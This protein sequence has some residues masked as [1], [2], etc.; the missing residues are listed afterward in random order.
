MYVN[1]EEHNQSCNDISSAIAWLSN[2]MD[3]NRGRRGEI[4]VGD[5]PIATVERKTNATRIKIIGSNQNHFASGLTLNLS[6]PVEF[7]NAVIQSQGVRQS[8]GTNMQVG[9]SIKF[10]SVTQSGGSNQELFVGV[11]SD[12]DLDFGDLRQES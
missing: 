6:T 1:N 2:E 5:A 9:G 7:D 12:E 10:G 4:R 8:F 3:A 11:D